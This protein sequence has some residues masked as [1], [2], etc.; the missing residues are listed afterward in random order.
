M[1]IGSRRWRE[2]LTYECTHCA[3][4]T[5]RI[6]HH[7]GGGF[8][9][10]LRDSHPNRAWINHGHPMHCPCAYEPG[11]ENG[12]PGGMPGR[13]AAGALAPPQSLGVPAHELMQQ[14]R[15]RVPFE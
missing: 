3:P 13:F 14:P 5:A 1:I 4:Q 9:L 10:W 2:E 7:G 11:P 12:L 6:V 15:G 8:K